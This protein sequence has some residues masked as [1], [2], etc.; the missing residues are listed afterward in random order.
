MSQL[1]YFD[2]QLSSLSDIASRMLEGDDN[3]AYAS[4]SNQERVLMFQYGV[5]LFLEYP[6]TG[7]GVNQFREYVTEMSGGV[8]KNDAHNFYMKVLV[9]E[10][11]IGS[12]VF[13]IPIVILYKR[14]LK[15][16]KSSN[17]EISTNARIFLALFV[18]G[19]VVNLFLASKSLTWTYYLLPCGL[20]LGLEKQFFISE[21]K[22]EK[23]YTN[24][25]RNQ[26]TYT[27]IY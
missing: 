8:L 23:L 2:R 25:G 10:G 12:F 11:L 20:L 9:E 14:L 15:A 3:S 5:N 4:S 24:E 7:V 26:R 18:L 27:G 22:K 6:I 1:K 17:I 13:L 16:S 21:S 19:A